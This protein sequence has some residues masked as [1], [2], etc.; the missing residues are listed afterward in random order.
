MLTRA[1][2]VLW[3]WKTDCADEGGAGAVAVDEPVK[4]VELFSLFISAIMN[5]DS[6]AAL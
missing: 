1:V 4:R 3:L 2:L 5:Y 6:L